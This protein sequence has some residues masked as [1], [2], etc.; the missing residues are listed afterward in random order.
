M[1]ESEEEFVIKRFAQ[2]T[3]IRYAFTS[4]FG[5]SNA[6]SIYLLLD[7]KLLLLKES[8]VCGS[9][10][11]LLNHGKAITE[12]LMKYLKGMIKKLNV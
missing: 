7:F 1:Q 5:L 12:N 6:M 4:E 3:I 9:Q 10:Q 11:H 8:C 2:D